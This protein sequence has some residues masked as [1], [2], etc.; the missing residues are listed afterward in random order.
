MTHSPNYTAQDRGTEGGYA[1][2]YRGM[3]VTAA[4]KR[5]LAVA[6]FHSN[7]GDRIADM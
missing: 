5:S 2:Y 7:P 4:S 6:H 1:E 3:D